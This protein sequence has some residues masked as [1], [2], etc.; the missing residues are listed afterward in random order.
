MLAII[1]SSATIIVVATGFAGQVFCSG[2][3][4]PALST[5]VSS[6]SLSASDQRAP[7]QGGGVRIP[8]VTGKSLSQRQA[9]MGK[10]WRRSLQKGLKLKLREGCECPSSS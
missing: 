3:Y 5:V 1:I 8:K 4:Y 6:F 7:L 10:T 9:E 2:S